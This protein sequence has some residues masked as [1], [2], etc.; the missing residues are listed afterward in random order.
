MLWSTF[1]QKLASEISAESLLPAGS[2]VVVAVSGGVDSVLLFV[3][4]ASLREQLELSELVVAYVDHGLRP[5]QTPDEARWVT[6]LAEQYGCRCFVRPIN[7]EVKDGSLQAAAR[8]ARRETLE[9]LL[10]E[11]QLDWI[12]TGHHADDQAETLLLRLLRGTGPQGLGGI[13]PSQGS[14]VHPLLPFYRMELLSVAKEKG[15]TWL[16]DPSNTSYQYTRNRVRHE[17]L[18]MLEEAYNPRLRYHLNHLSAQIRQDEEYLNSQLDD[19]WDEAMS[20]QTD[21]GWCLHLEAWERLPQPLQR[22]AMQR[23]VR[24]TTNGHDLPLQHIDALMHLAR[25]RHGEQTIPLPKP[26]Q[27]TRQYNKLYLSFEKVQ[28]SELFS[29]LIQGSGRFLC[30]C[31]VLEV[32][33]WSGDQDSRKGK[34]GAQY[35]EAFLEEQD[36][37]ESPWILRNRAPGD[38]LDFETHHRPLKKWMIDAKIPR[39]F[40]YQIPLLERQGTIRWVIGWRPLPPLQAQPPSKGWHFR[41]MPDNVLIFQSA[42][43]ENADHAP[44]I[45]S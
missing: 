44:D 5:E 36:L 20:T 40:R 11:E 1:L 9:K 24:V 39:S 32:M 31:G 25:Q 17:L 12:A 4:L 33:R 26:L 35:W 41:F 27:V 22:R 8:L 43:T 34:T 19:C 23:L 14:W 21:T 42:I 45:C 38:R 13:A 29:I 30:P 2:R 18:P 7:I 3:G 37:A 10:Q 28:T 16:E 15:L 6:A